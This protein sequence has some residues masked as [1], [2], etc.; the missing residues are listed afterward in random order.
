[1]PKTNMP[2]KPLLLALGVIIVGVGVDGTAQRGDQTTQ[3]PPASNSVRNLPP[4]APLGAPAITPHRAGVPAFTIDD[5]TKYVTTHA[6]ALGLRGDYRS[7]TLQAEFLTSQQVSERL[8]GATTGF[9]ADHL[10]CYVELRGTFSFSGPQG[11]HVTYPRGI[12]IFDAQTG[13]LVIH[14]GMQ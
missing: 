14:G 3:A 4:T 8:Q 2:M 11:A 5:A 6:R 13:H 12:F 1:M 9:P 10:L 7:G